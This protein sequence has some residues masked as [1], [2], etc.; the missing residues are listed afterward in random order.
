[1]LAWV[2]EGMDQYFPAMYRTEPDGCCGQNVSC[3]YVNH[4][5]H[6]IGDHGCEVEFNY[7]CELG[8]LKLKLCMWSSL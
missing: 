4:W 1:M 5:T 3:I 6:F 8:K 2:Q 7:I